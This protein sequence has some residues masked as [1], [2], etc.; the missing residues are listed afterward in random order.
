MW[1]CTRACLTCT[2]VY[3]RVRVHVHASE[4]TYILNLYITYLFIHIRYV[5]AYVWA[6]RERKMGRL[7][8]LQHEILSCRPLAKKLSFEIHSSSPQQK[9]HRSVKEES[10]STHINIQTVAD[11][12][13]AKKPR[14]HKFTDQHYRFIDDAMA[15]SDQLTSRQLHHLVQEAFPGV[16]V[17]ISTIKRARRELG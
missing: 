2:Y 16:E 9:K 13:R 12:R 3:T 5:N 11:A 6:R 4:C 14:P 1:H 15:E 8:R 10:L 17:S 7:Y